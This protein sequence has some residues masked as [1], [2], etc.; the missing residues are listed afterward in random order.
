MSPSLSSTSALYL[1]QQNVLTFALFDWWAV[2]F[3]KLQRWRKITFQS[4]VKQLE[5]IVYPA[6][7]CFSSMSLFLP[8]LVHGLWFCWNGAR[9]NGKV[10][11]I[12]WSVFIW[13]VKILEKFH[14]PAA[15]NWMCELRHQKL[16]CYYKGFWKLVEIGLGR[17]ISHIQTPNEQL[18]CECVCNF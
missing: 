8:L 6:I 10:L 11:H 17:D 7:F 2:S 1:C 9:A 15:E 5:P 12:S 3:W 4:K 13:S 14:S 18:Q 16:I